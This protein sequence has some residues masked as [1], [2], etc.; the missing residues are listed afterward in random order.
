MRTLRGR[1]LAYFGLAVA[2]SAILTVLVAGFLSRRIIDR[3]VLRVLERQVEVAAAGLESENP[4]A[5]KGLGVLFRSQGLLLLLPSAPVGEGA[6]LRSRAVSTR[7]PSGKIEVLGRDF[8]FAVADTSEGPIVLTRP[9]NVRSSDWGPYLAILLVAGAGGGLVAVGLSFFLARRISRPLRQ[10]SDAGRRLA[11]GELDTRVPVESRDELGVLASSFNEM[12]EQLA[13]ARET[14]RGFLMSVSHEL[15]TPLTA[16]RGYA[17]ALGDGATTPEEA[18]A[19]IG[20]EADRLERLVRDLLDLA[21]LD[22]RQFSVA[23]EPLDLIDVVREVEHRHAA[24]AGEF[25]VAL[26]VDA[27]GPARAI[28]DRD[29]M[30]QVVSNL[31]ENALRFTPAGGRVV[32]GASEGL[33]TVEDTGPGLAPE[34][35][36]HAFDR[37]F[38][39]E[40]YRADRPV[41]SGLGLA[42]VKELVQAMGGT[43]SV[44]SEPGAGAVFRIRLITSGDAHPQPAA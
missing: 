35:L 9:A 19:V 34:D 10:V 1:L 32:I 25:G 27:D 40:R 24:R 43:V 38:L 16:I 13:I 42:I 37:L 23:R 15:K 8:F 12:A 36:P 44:R 2:V 22:Q 39:H 14:E 30:V 26:S 41:G 3:Q 29:R 21:K 31:V 28:G 11:A 5:E 4:A 17:E 18:A 20:R 6:A 7:E 33:V